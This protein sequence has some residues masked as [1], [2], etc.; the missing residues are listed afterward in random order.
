MR[1]LQDKKAKTG[2]RRIHRRLKRRRRPKAVR[3]DKGSEFYNR[4]FKQCFRGASD[5]II[6]RPERKQNQLCREVHSDPK[7]EALSL[8]HTRSKTQVHAHFTG[9]CQVHQRHAQPFVEGKSSGTIL[10]A[11]LRTSSKPMAQYLS[12]VYTIVLSNV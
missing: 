7:K 4:Y 12:F 11:S 6:L 2:D 9:R 8:S 1:P 3:T 10:M 5:Q